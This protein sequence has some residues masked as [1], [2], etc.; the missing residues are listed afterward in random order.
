MNEPNSY[1]PGEYPTSPPE[2]IFDEPAAVSSTTEVATSGIGGRIALGVMA[3]GLVAAGGFAARA[4]LAPP[5]GPSSSDEAITQFFAALDNDDLVGMAE[6][7]HP[8]E[9]ESIA[10]PMFTMLEHVQRLEIVAAEG[11]DPEAVTFTDT[12]VEGLTY[13]IEETGAR[14]HYVTTTGGTVTTPNDSSMPGGAL[15]DRFDIDFPEVDSGTSVVDLGDDPVKMAVVEDDG[16]WYV[17]LWY[18]VAEDTRRNEGML[19]SELGSGPAPV[20]AASPDAVMEDMMQAMSDLNPRGVLTLLDPREAAV[21]YDYSSLYLSDIDDAM[22][23]A[24]A[25]ADAEG[26]SWTLDAVDFDAKEVNGRQVVTLSTMAMSI[27]YEQDG[28]S[29]TASV[30]LVDGCTIV[31]VASETTDSC[32]QAQATQTEEFEQLSQQGLDILGLSDV[33]LNAFEKLG[34]VETG[35]TVIE[36]DG[37]WYLSLVPTALEAVNDHLAVLEPEDLVAMGT[38]IEEIYEDSD[39]VLEEMVDLISE[40]DWDSLEGNE[41]GAV[42]LGELL[43][44]LSGTTSGETFEDVSPTIGDDDV[45]GDPDSDPF[46][47]AELGPLVDVIENPDMWFAIDYDFSYLSWEAWALET[48]PYVAGG[49][50]TGDGFIEL[51]QFESPVDPS[52]LDPDAWTLEVNG[53][54]TTATS[55]AGGTVFAFVGDY[56]VWHGGDEA[57]MAMAADQIARLP[58]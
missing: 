6:L 51:L 17:S 32:E 18:S 39:R 42:A 8:A 16:S 10:D 56:V 30:E 11:T 19:F 13:T 33:T 20:G 1:L 52:S 49:Y 40:T 31:T 50:T 53:D 45:F 5:A 25:E 4:A 43:G 47:E 24:R 55:T 27:E 15:F 12:Q 29:E 3:I 46:A 41:G 35:L 44:E 48:P 57:S 2:F 9:R 54:I 7:V 28:Q 22:D 26:I 38:D 23:E 37:R 34:N 21:L 14:L 58:R 36:R